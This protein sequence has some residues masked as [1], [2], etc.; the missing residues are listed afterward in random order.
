ME[1]FGINVNRMTIA[2]VIGALFGIFCAWATSNAPIPAQWLTVEFLIYIWYNRLILGFVLGI[3]DNI[4]II[5]SKYGNSIVR[6]AIIGTIVSVILVII[7]GWP[8]ISYLFA[9]TIYGIVI[10]LIATKFG[11]SEK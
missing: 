1:K 2:L 9:G 4:K 3:S 6:G 8:A 10:D 11:K 7:P 5:K